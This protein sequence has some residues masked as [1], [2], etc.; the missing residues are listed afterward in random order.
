VT[1]EPIKKFAIE[2]QSEADRYLE[3]LLAKSEFTMDDVEVFARDNISDPELY[4]Y[5]I[6]KAKVILNQKLA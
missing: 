4:E 6:E 1:I 2:N 5:V 3:A